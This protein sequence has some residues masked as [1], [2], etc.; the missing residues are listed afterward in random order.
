MTTRHKLDAK[1]SFE[2]AGLHWT[3]A[4]E[5]NWVVLESTLTNDQLVDLCIE[6][7]AIALKL[8]K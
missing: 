6:L 7:R 1:R 3:A 8:E 4:E 2:R 5:N